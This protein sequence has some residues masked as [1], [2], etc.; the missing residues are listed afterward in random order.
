MPS[1]SESSSSESP[2]TVSHKP[3]P[4]T[5]SIPPVRS[6]N[7]RPPLRRP[8]R[9]GRVS[10]VVEC[11]LGP[12]GCIGKME[13]YMGLVVVA[14]CLN[15]TI[16]AGD[17][18]TSSLDCN[19]GGETTTLPSGQVDNSPCPSLD[20]GFGF[21]G[22]LARVSVP[23]SRVRRVFARLSNSEWSAS[24]RLACGRASRRAAMSSRRSSPE[25]P[26]CAR[27]WPSSG[28]APWFPELRSRRTSCSDSK[29]V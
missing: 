17:L 25:P 20:K 24:P 16:P 14:L 7:R 19:R 18:R 28:G 22:G 15:P 6:L 5:A 13:K 12:E 11:S 2:M 10:K 4:A 21:S 9:V 1:R 27:I 26:V 3:D 29:Q 23:G 8:T